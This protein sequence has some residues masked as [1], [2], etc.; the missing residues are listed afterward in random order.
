MVLSSHIANGAVTT[1]QIAANTIVNGNVA[2]GTFG[3]ISIPAPNVNAGSL[4]AGVIASSIAVGAITSSAQIAANTITN[5]N[6]AAGTFGNISIPAPNVNAGSLGAGVIA[7]SLAVNGVTAGSYGTSTQVAAYTVGVDGRITSA[8]NI[9]ITGAAP[10]GPAGG[11]LTGNFPNP[12]FGSQVVLSSHIANGAVTTTQI[13][14][15]TIVNGNVAAGTF[16]N[17]SIPAPNVNAGSLGAGVIASSLAVNGVTAGSYGSGTQ[18]AAYTVGVDGRITSAS[19]IT[20][21]GAAP[22][23]AAGGVL[24]GSFPNRRSARRS[25]FPHI[26]PT[27]PSPRLR[28]RPT[29]SSTATWRPAPSATS[30]SP[31]RTSMRARSAPASSLRASRSMVLRPAATVPARRSRPTPSASTA[32]SRRLRTSRSP[33]PLR[34]ERGGRSCGQL[35]EPDARLA[36]RAFLAH[37]QRRRHHD[38][39]RGQHDRQRQRGGR[40]LRQYLDP[41][42]Q[43]QCGLAR[44]RRHRFEPRGQRCYGRQL[45]LGHAGG[46]LHCR[47]RRPHHVGLQHH[48][49]RRGPERCRRRRPRWKL[50]E[51]DA[52]LAGR[53]VLPHRQRRRHHD[54]DRGQHD[55]QRQRGGRDL[56]QHLDPGPERQRR[57]ARRRRDRLELGGQWCHGRQL[58][59]RHSG[60]GLH[61]RRRRPHHVGLQHHDHRRRSDRRGGG[62]ACGSFPNPTLGSQVVLS[63]HIANGAVTTTQIAANTIVNG[64]V[65]AGTFGN[66]SIPAPNVNAG[67]LGAG[68][69]ASSLAVNGVTAGSYGSGRRSRP[70]LSAS[71]AASRRPP[72]SPSPARPR[73]VR[74]RR[75]RWKLSEPDARLAGRFVL[76]IANGAVTTTQIA[77]NTIVNGNV[78]AGTFGNI[79]IPAPNVNAGSLGAGVIASSIAVG[80]ITSSAQIG[81]GVPSAANHAN[82]SLTNAQMAAGTFGNIS[83]P[84]PNVNAGSLGAG[85]IASSLAV[86]G[87]TAGSYG[88]GTQVAAYTVGVDGRI[89]S[90]SNVTITGAAPTGTAGGVLGQLPNPTLGSQVVLSSHIANGAVTT[91]QIA[92]N[93]IVNGNVAAGTFGNI[94]I[95]APNVNAG[96]LGAGVIASS[97][98]V[99]GVTAGS[100]GSGTQVAAYT[101]GVDGRITLASNITI[102]G[103]APAVPPAAS[104]LEAIRAR[105]SARRWF[106]PRTSPTAPSP[107][108]RSPPT[109]SSTATWPPAPSATSRSP[110]RTS[111]RAHSAPASSLRASRL[112]VL[113]PA[114]TVPALRSR[115]TLSASTAASRRL[116]TSR[117]PAPLRPER[118]AASSLESYPSPTLGSQVVLSSHI[119]NGAVTTTQIAANTIVNGNV[120]A[121]TF[122]NISI[123]APNVNAGSLGAG[124]IASSLAVNGVTAGSYGSGTQVAAYTVGVD[125]RITSASNITITGAAP[126]GAAGG[127]LAG[128]FPNPT[129]G[130]QVVLSS[131]IA[132]GAVT[133]TL[134]AATSTIVNGNVAAGT[135][136]NISIP[137][138]ERQCGLARR[139]RH[140]FEPRG[141]RC[142]GR[143]LRFR[144]AG[145]GPTLSASTA[146]ITSASNITITGAAP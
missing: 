34:P 118:P 90:A 107:R 60:R 35:P 16:G 22:T 2:A 142:D 15:N 92:A 24:A 57:L 120:A 25:F 112:T 27:A 88:S 133:T 119:A 40:H 108:L 122:G 95:P 20:I 49:H 146:R 76:A 8:S 6:V 67:S 7:S 37:R 89:T 12:T 69:I 127:V 66:I 104:S 21:T 51:P 64:N 130:S 109:P 123:P 97:L 17:I 53:S 58:R 5:G 33:A 9:T 93:T 85:V 114:A 78:A 52:R 132:N 105:R 82:N 102:T 14:A 18:V 72:T 125:G 77:A 100:Y 29:R 115:P 144:H 62:R 134:I 56:R 68:V 83:I 23:G 70:T 26:S 63:S 141:Q 4:G 138:P 94:S 135:F 96:S 103:A 140:R 47:R 48:D 81:A 43:R 106:C 65:A 10:T 41:G 139:R 113:P 128:S 36:G 117:S 124:V 145:R 111:T 80:A 126:T 19:N 50:S 42:A 101:V 54:S 31:P 61:C 44:R 91:T 143:Q 79:S 38:S 136:G 30:R 73:A 129:L 84:A 131:H 1:T 86:N 39:D 121:G 3:N 11:V 45:R 116:R 87:V 71:T 137:A 13:A 59:F 74:R 75:P 32:A 99:N 46:G 55:R 110:H 98:A 28:S